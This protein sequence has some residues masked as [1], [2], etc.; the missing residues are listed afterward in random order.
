M[1]EKLKVNVKGKSKGIAFSLGL[2]GDP[3]SPS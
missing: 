2:Q 3:T 1:K